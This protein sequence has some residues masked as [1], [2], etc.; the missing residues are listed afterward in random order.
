MVPLGILIRLTLAQL[1]LLL[2]HPVAAVPLAQLLLLLH[3]V[4]AVPDA[5]SSS[6][7]N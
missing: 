5:Q 6:S 1:L 4:A 3:P 2:L 7:A